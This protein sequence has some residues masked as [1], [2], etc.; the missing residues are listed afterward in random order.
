MEWSQLKSRLDSL[1]ESD[2]KSEL[3]GALRMLNRVDV[4]EYLSELDT[5]KM[6]RVFRMLPTDISSESDRAAPVTN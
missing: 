5:D 6:L 4:A 1:L 3:R 2:K